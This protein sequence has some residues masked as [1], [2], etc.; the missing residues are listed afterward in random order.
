MKY[1]ET[2]LTTLSK[3]FQ[4]VPLMPMRDEGTLNV[5]SIVAI[6]S[7]EAPK[8]DIKPLNHQVTLKTNE[9]RHKDVKKTISKAYDMSLLVKF[10]GGGW[11]VSGSGAN[12]KSLNM[13]LLVTERK[14]FTSSSTHEA[15][16]TAVKKEFR[17]L[18]QRHG[19]SGYLPGPRLI[20]G[21]VTKVHIG[22]IKICGREQQSKRLQ[23]QIVA[24]GEGAYNNT[25][26]E[27]YERNGILGIEMVAFTAA[28][29]SDG[30]WELSKGISVQRLDYPELERP[31]WWLKNGDTKSKGGFFTIRQTGATRGKPETLCIVYMEAEATHKQTNLVWYAYALLVIL[32]IVLLGHDS[33]GG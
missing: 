29:Q 28:A 19:L 11:S 32:C 12:G 5:G 33:E 6:A 21:V 30:S 15:I 16:E 26:G 7:S 10:V 24:E 2:V 23:A 8:V 18:M 13:S 22:M 4:C 9:K 31:L 25:D 14:S 1:Q 17:R 27:I 20:F 3:E